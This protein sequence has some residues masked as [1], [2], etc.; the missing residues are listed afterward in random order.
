MAQM[1]EKVRPAIENYG[2]ALQRIK[3]YT[4]LSAMAMR[5]DRYVVSDEILQNA[6]MAVTAAR[7]V[8]YGSDYNNAEFILGFCLLWRGDLDEAEKQFGISIQASE[9]TGDVTT[10]SRCLTYLT[11]IYRKRCDP[12]N[13]CKYAEQSRDVSA[14][15]Q[16]IEYIGMAQANLA[17]AARRDARLSEAFELSEQAWETMQKTPQAQMFAW[18]V[19][20]P[21]VA[22]T[23]A[24]NRIAESVGFARKL[25]GPTTQPQPDAI[26]AI[27]LAAIQAWEQENPEQA[28]FCLTQAISLAEPLGYL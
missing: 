22:I 10:L 14:V 5:R 8:G 19:V 12:A 28:T 2:T 16:M 27:L 6:R 4:N 23:L 11:I 7:E 1:V 24:Q 13:V 15:G 21:L 3:F 25:F 18:V 26:A 17:W 9:R 20:W